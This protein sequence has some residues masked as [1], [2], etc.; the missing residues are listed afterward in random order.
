MK[1]HAIA[2]LFAPLGLLAACHSESSVE[3]V[4]AEQASELN[5]IAANTSET[6]G[7]EAMQDNQQAVGEAYRSGATKRPRKY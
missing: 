5:A 4:N 1:A 3:H 6:A 2:M 7:A